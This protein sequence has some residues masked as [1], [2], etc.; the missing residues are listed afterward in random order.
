MQRRIGFVLQILP[1][2]RE[3]ESRSVTAYDGGSSGW[4]SWV[5]SSFISMSERSRMFVLPAFKSNVAETADASLD[6]TA[7]AVDAAPFPSCWSFP[8][9][10]AGN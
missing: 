1:F 6:M 2:R 4:Q 5:F 10:G 9:F 3:I 8:A 7:E